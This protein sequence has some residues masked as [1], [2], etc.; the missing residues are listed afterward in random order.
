MLL[1]PR[2]LVIPHIRD[3]GNATSPPVPSMLKRFSIS[4]NRA[5]EMLGAYVLLELLHGRSA[6]DLGLDDCSMG[7]SPRILCSR[8]IMACRVR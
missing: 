8:S 1:K 5:G 3:Q 7:D 6:I 4:V 2:S